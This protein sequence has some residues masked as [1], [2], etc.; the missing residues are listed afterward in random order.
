MSYI[1][2]VS[3]GGASADAIKSMIL[4]SN[5]LLESMGN[6]MTLRNN[7]SS[8]FGKYFELKFDHSGIPRAG[9]ITNYLLGQ[10]ETMRNDESL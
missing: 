4:E 7:N 10:M 2:A 6:A 8:R 1:S 3:G 9:Y 5:P